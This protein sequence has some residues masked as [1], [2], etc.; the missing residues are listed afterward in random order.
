MPTSS[1]TELDTTTRLQLAVSDICGL[2][3]N[4]LGNVLNAA[5]QR[6]VPGAPGVP[7]VTADF[8][9][10]VARA[11]GEIDTLVG[12]L[13]RG[14]RDEEVQLRRLRE[15]EEEHAAV[16]RELRAEVEAAGAH[17]LQPPNSRCWRAC[18][19]CGL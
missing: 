14:Y 19:H 16:T 10:Q 18:R 5:E 7:A 1:L 11:H 3:S 15:L 9:A 8:G 4:A 6:A 13:C 12:E 2:Y 17:G